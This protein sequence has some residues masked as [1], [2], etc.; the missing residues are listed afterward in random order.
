MAQLIVRNLDE[1][2]PLPSMSFWLSGYPA[3][4][5]RSTAKPLRWRPIWL[6]AGIVPGAPP[7][8]ATR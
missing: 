5:R 4:Y 8:S 1:G 7:A 3:A 2:V 6:H